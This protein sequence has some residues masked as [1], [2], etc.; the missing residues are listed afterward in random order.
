MPFEFE[1]TIQVTLDST[2]M[3]ISTMVGYVSVPCVCVCVC[4]VCLEE[5]FVDGKERNVADYTR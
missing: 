4:V 5:S 2:A 1:F 3:H